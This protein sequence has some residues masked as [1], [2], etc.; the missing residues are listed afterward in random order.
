M[1]WF[2]LFLDLG[3]WL[4][5]SS[6]GWLG[7]LILASISGLSSRLGLD[8]LLSSFLNLYFLFAL[9]YKFILARFKI[10]ELIGGDGPI[11][12]Q[13]RFLF[14]FGE[15][16]FSLRLLSIILFL[17]T[18]GSIISALSAELSNLE[19]FLM[20][21]NLF[22][23]VLII[24]F[25]DLNAEGRVRVTNMLD[26]GFIIVLARFNRITWLPLSRHFTLLLLLLGKLLLVGL[27]VIGNVGIIE[28][29]DFDLEFWTRLW[30]LLLEL[31]LVLWFW[32]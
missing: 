5:G 16:S 24:K 17:D 19:G 2:F 31:F 18:L 25:A 23:D 15:C 6:G 20:C 3:C 29:V 9:S 14:V 22:I 12:V 7:S 4:G 30:L 28:R 13:A 32:L 21:F 8:L 11:L 26:N 27:N 1:F 10:L